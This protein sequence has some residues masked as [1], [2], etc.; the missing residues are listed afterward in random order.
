MITYQ[1]L[2]AVGENEQE[3]I[4]FVRRVIADHQSS[5][6]YRE[7][8]IADE[9]YRH[10]NRTIRQFQK[11]IHTL[12]G[13]TKPD[14]YAA[15]SKVASNY[16]K[17]FVM[18]ETQY[19]LG[20]GVTW[21]DKATA[22][23]LGKT[24][25]NRLQRAAKKALVCGV[26]FGFFNLD[27]MDVFS[28]LEFAPLYDEENG[29]LSAGVRFWQIDSSKPLRATLYELDGYTDY[30]WR[31]GEGEILHEKRPYKI[32]L[33]YSES[34]GLEIY[35]GENYPSFP[36]IPLFANEEHQSE[37]TGN[38]EGI[39]VYDFVKSGFADDLSETQEIFWL[40]QNAGGMDDIDLAEFMHRIKML[41]AAALQDGQT[42]EAKTQEVPYAARQTMLDIARKDLYRDFMALNTE[43]IASGAVTATQIEAS[44]EALEAKTDDFEYCVLEFIEGILKVAG[45]TDEA[46][47]TRSKIVNR[48]DEIQN[49]ISG[50]EYLSQEYCTTKILT[51][52]GDADQVD[53]VMKQLSA[54]DTIDLTDDTNDEPDAD[55]Q[56][57]GNLNG[58]EN[59]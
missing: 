3:R 25:D 22:D 19:L 51:L 24:F 56:Q 27:H 41:H 52:L 53:E 2:I 29:A 48:S 17:R 36:I 59:A 40:I 8:K 18:Q 39:D 58:E 46:T 9:Y 5:E 47:F 28:F 20:N 30:I 32:N 6:A 35:D 21:N 31:D 55:N 16:F 37:L 12:S 26:S 43:D 14:P 34:D 11:M 1:D 45:I 23:K 54:Q 33:R 4:G 10:K 7:A 49:V 13:K 50:G 44:Y 42:V 38:R 57:E 15:N